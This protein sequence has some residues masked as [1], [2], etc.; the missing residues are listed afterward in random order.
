MVYQKYFRRFSHF[1]V[2]VLASTSFYPLIEMTYKLINNM[3]KMAKYISV[4]QNKL[5]IGFQGNNWFL[6]DTVTIEV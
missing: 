3:L 5:R 2:A 6:F 4:L 1:E